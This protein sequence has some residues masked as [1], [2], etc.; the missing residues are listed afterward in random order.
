MMPRLGYPTENHDRTGLAGWPPAAIAPTCG[1][2]AKRSLL[3]QRHY[4]HI[5][6]GLLCGVLLTRSAPRD[7]PLG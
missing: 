6:G 1:V 5:A 3:G 4:R 2:A 7:L